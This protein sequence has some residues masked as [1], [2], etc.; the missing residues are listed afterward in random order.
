[1][2]KLNKPLKRDRLFEQVACG[3]SFTCPQL[4][5]DVFIKTSLYHTE[6]HLKYNAFNILSGQFAYFNGSDYV[7]LVNGT[8]TLVEQIMPL[9]IIIFMNEEGDIVD[10]V[11]TNNTSD[12]ILAV[13]REL[14]KSRGEQITPYYAKLE[15]GE[16]Y[17]DRVHK[18]IK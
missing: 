8:L 13:A 11:S 4:L 9:N 10:Y 7:I 5:D 3:V 12:F 17:T 6:P 14:T 18:D 1:M 15:V 16:E 2:I